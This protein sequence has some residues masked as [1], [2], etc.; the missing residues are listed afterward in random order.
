MW[1]TS[2]SFHKMCLFH[3]NENL[4][5]YLPSQRQGVNLT[6]NLRKPEVRSCQSLC[7]VPIVT[8]S[9]FELIFCFCMRQGFFH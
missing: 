1:E 9:S 6:F 2:R 3:L 4:C 8:L 7:G 5:F